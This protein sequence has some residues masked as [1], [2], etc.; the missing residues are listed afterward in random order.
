LICGGPALFEA[1]ENLILNFGFEIGVGIN[2]VKIPES[3]EDM[4]EACI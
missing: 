1:F 2:M 3:C 4:V